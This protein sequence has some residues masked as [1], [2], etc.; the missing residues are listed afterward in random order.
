M[1]KVLSMLLGASFFISVAAQSSIPHTT[2]II[3]PDADGK[4]WN[5][6]A[7]L[8]AGKVVVIHQEFSG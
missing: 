4:T 3:V 7:L 8:N 6:D 1:K 2:G 5:L